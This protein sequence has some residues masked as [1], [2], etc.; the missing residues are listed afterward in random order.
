MPSD[1]DTSGDLQPDSGLVF[2]WYRFT[3]EDGSE[4]DWLISRSQNNV[5]VWYGRTGN[6][7]RQRTTGISSSKKGKDM[8]FKRVSEKVSKGYR[9]IGRAYVKKNKPAPLDGNMPESS[10]SKE[11]DIYWE[12]FETHSLDW[13]H[14]ISVAEAMCQSGCRVRVQ[15]DR[16]VVGA[17]VELPMNRTIR[18]NEKTGILQRT[19]LEEL[20]FLF[21][22]LKKQPANIRVLVNDGKLVTKWSEL[23]IEQSDLPHS[24]S[25][26]LE[27]VGLIF[28]QLSKIASAGGYF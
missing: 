12:L 16:L 23:E 18:S 27:C 2:D 6:T 15:E 5:V 20:V 26:A 21:A 1:N 19:N 8:A 11:E 10:P 24:I 28:P 9:N 3:N 25:D 7:L 14:A 22:I 17:K 13:P 4:K